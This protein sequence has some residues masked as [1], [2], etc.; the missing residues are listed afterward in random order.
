MTEIGSVTFAAP[1]S[2]SFNPVSV[3]QPMRDVSV[4]VLDVNDP[5][6]A[7]S[8]GVEGEIAVRAPSMFDGY[9]SSQAELIDGHFRTG[10]LGHLDPAGNLVITGRV[11]LLIDTGGVKVNPLEVEAVL[12]SHPQVAECAVVPVRQSETVQRL[13]AYV[14][15]RDPDVPP[16]IIE[17]R[18]FTKERLASYKVPRL[19]EFTAALPRTEAGKVKRQLL[20][21]AT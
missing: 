1:S 3:G 9:V 2:P 19:F 7:A 4:S 21:E 16:D 18:R 15:P 11:R 13:K 10:D 17:L 14:V 6:R 12:G 20:Q 8:S 5:T